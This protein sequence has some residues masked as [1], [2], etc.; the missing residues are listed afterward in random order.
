M[1]DWAM[2]GSV[3]LQSLL[4]ET[5]GTLGYS[6]VF[7]FGLRSVKGTVRTVACKEKTGEWDFP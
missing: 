2:M 5:I 7:G 4:L 6:A 1:G 3:G